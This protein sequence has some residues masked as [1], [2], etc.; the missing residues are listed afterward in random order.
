MR[1]A[2]KGKNK[3]NSCTKMCNYNKT[4]TTNDRKTGEKYTFQR[5]SHKLRLNRLS[6]AEA[7]MI[8]DILGYDLEFIE[9]K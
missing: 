4:C 8:A 3:I 5:I 6:L 9:R 2:N 7:Y 1:Y